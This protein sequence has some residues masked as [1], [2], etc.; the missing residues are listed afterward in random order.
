M[1]ERVLC[2]VIHVCGWMSTIYVMISGVDSPV[3]TDNAWVVVILAGLMVTMAVIYHPEMEFPTGY[4]TW[5]EFQRS[6]FWAVV[7]C[8][9]V[10]TVWMKLWYQ[11]TCD[12]A[13]TQVGNCSYEH[14][15]FLLVVFISVVIALVCVHCSKQQYCFHWAPEPQL[16]EQDIQNRKRYRLVSLPDDTVALAVV[17]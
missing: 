15:R 2:S 3:D 4:N 14:G 13:P 11:L 12:I 1:D 8:Q 9:M 5:D 17:L 7:K 6:A 16:S 10:N